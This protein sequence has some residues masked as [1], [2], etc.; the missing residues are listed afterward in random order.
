MGEVWDFQFL[1]A[2]D[3]VK[4]VSFAD[5]SIGTLVC[6][7]NIF[8][9]VD[10][11]ATWQLQFTS[12][13]YLNGVSMSDANTAT[14][15]GYWG[16]IL[17]TTDGGTTWVPQQT[18]TTTTLTSVCF[19]DANH[20]TAVGWSGTILGTADGGA[21]WTRQE[22]G[23]NKDLKSVCFT[24]VNHGAV[25][26]D[27]GTILQTTTG[28]YPTAVKSAR[29]EPVPTKVALFQNYPN[30]FNPITTIRYSLPRRGHVRL[31]VFNTLGQKVAVLVNGDNDTGPHEVH[32]NASNLASGVYFYRLQANGCLE[33]R[34]LVLQR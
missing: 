15:V 1:P 34:K 21:T 4:S 28:G 30:P 25:V 19:A 20:G 26:G 10:G 23:T 27:E 9:T 32:F 13:S 22:S 6:G 7:S 29:E 31:T 8:R 33:V 18:G 2:S 5:L 16:T 17:R 3:D 12:T 14:A 24:D 11:G